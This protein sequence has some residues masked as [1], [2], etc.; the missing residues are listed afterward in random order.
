MRARKGGEF[1][2]PK[3]VV[4][5]LVECL[6]PR[7]GMSLY[8]PCC[9]SG[10]MLLEAAGFLARQGSRADSLQLF[11]QEMNVNTWAICQINLLLHGIDNS[12]V[13]RGGYSASPLPLG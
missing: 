7:A 12:S 13:E 6:Q 1:Y 11:G 10:G 8:D 9:G 2:T 4:R 5:L 3:Q